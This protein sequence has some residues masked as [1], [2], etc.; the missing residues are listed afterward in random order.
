MT[1]L[2]RI[3]PRA[4][5]DLIEIA[6]YT[7]NKWGSQQRNRYLKN[8]ELRFLWLADNPHLG[9][10]RQDIHGGYYCYPQGEHLIFYLLQ[11][12]GI[13]IIGIPHQRRDVV[14]YF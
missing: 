11:P 12:Q 13:D 14:N 5:D 1:K 9:K 7:S 4:R 10:E 3:T 8:L 6:R 2:Y